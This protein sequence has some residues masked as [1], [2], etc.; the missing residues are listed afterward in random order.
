MFPKVNALVCRKYSNTLRDS[1]F[2]QLQWAIEK[3]GLYQFKCTVSPMKIEYLPT[4][5]QIIFRGVD[6]P[7]KLKSLKLKSGYFGILWFEES[8]GSSRK[9]YDRSNRLSCAAGKSSGYSTASILLSIATTGRIK[10][11]YLISRG[12]AYYINLITGKYR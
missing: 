7:V 10:T 8:T 11:R 4:G 2:E 9:R 3:L 1:V 6:K 5:Q 12:V